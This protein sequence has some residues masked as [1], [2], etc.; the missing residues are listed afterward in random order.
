MTARAPAGDPPDRRPG[1][2]RRDG[3]RR[4]LAAVRPRRDDGDDR[5]PGGARGDQRARGQAPRRRGRSASSRR[6]GTSRTALIR[7]AER[8]GAALAR[9]YDLDLADDPGDLEL[10]LALAAPDRRPD[11]RARGR[12]GPDRRPARARRATRHRRRPRPGDA[13]AGASRARGAPDRRRPTG[14]SWSRPTCS[15]CAS[16]AAGPYRLAF[17]ALNTIFLLATRER[18]RAGVPDAG[19]PPRAGRPRRRRHLAAGRRRPRPLRRP[20]DLRV[21]AAGPRDRRHR[22]EG[23]APPATTRRA[24]SSS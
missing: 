2:A 13:R 6:P 24:R 11:P 9:L 18:Q 23:R 16:P 8:R 17:I 4:G 12:H 7:R 19:R 10:Y 20:A 22:H 14:S 1:R 15:T 5:Q 21:R 3:H